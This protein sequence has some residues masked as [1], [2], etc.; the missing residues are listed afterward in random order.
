MTLGPHYRLLAFLFINT[1]AFQFFVP[2]LRYDPCLFTAVPYLE[3]V[4]YL[5]NV[6]L[7]KKEDLLSDD[8]LERELEL[9]DLS[10]LASG[11]EIDDDDLML[12]LEEMINS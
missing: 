7:K 4:I 11:E 12:E 5:R 10:S 9:D 1:Y 3:Y 6:E 2:R 8:E